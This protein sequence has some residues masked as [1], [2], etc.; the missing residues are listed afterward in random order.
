MRPLLKKM[1]LLIG[2]KKC[3]QCDVLSRRGTAMITL[4]I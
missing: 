3:E 1:L 4:N 2:C